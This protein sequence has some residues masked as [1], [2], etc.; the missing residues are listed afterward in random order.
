MVIG[1]GVGG[2]EA[3]IT[4]AQRGHTVDLYEKDEELGGLVQHVAS[5]HPRLNTRDL[6]NIVDYHVVQVEKTEGLTVHLETAVTAELVENENPDAVVVAVGSGEKLPEIPGI[7]LANVVTNEDY[8]RS[9]GEMEIGDTVVVIGGNYGAET[10]VS[11]AREG[12]KVTMVEES[13]THNRPT[14]SVDLYCRL[15]QLDGYVKDENIT[16]LTETR[17]VEINGDGVVVENAEGRKTL[18]AD[19]VIVAWDRQSRV[20]CYEALKGKVKEI[21]KIGDCKEARSIQW[22]IEE[23]ANVSRQI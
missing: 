13:E 6:R 4:C 7:D 20:E 14:Y 3:A 12:K 5:T 16:V 19:S 17:A 10:A 22:A 8:L 11:L 2:M 1:G 9:E 18:P 21:Y 15:F 23:A